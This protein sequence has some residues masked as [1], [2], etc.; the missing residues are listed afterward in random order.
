MG[1][2]G[3]HRP[4]RDQKLFAS[5]VGLS[6]EVTSSCLISGMAFQKVVAGALPV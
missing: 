6:V 2:A 5:W 4:V 3:L 1:V